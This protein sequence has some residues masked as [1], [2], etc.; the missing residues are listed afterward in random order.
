MQTNFQNGFGNILHGQLFCR[1][2]FNYPNPN[3]FRIGLNHQTT[4]TLSKRKYGP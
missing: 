1:N 3:P 4:E 2:V